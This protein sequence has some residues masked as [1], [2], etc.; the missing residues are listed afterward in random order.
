VLTV[1]YEKVFKILIDFIVATIQQHWLLIQ[2]TILFK[3][4]CI[5]YKVITTGQPSYLRTLL[6]YYTPNHALRSVAQC[7]LERLLTALAR[8]PGWIGWI[9]WT[10]PSGVLRV[11]TSAATLCRRP[12]LHG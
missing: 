11:W 9:C 8:R 7:L 2:S 6:Q 4:A 10:G 1:L 12:Y 3:V 5:I